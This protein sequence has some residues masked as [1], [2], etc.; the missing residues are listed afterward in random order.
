MGAPLGAALAPQ[1]AGASTVTQGDIYTVAG[2]G[3]Q[4][5][6]GD[7]GPA[8]SGELNLP[9]AV[10]VDASGN[11]LVGEEWG[12]RVRVVA[13]SASNPGYALAGCP[14]TCTWAQGDIYTVAGNGTGGYAGDAGPATSAE[15]NAPVSV[16][17]DASG[18]LIIGD[19]YSGHVRVV[20]MSASDPG[21]PLA[22]CPGTCT[23]A[24]GDIYTVAGNG[25]G[26][27]TGDGGP[28][29]S[30]ELSGPEGITQGGRQSDT[31]VS[32]LV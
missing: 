2:N 27:Y 23:W 13:M 24:Q 3:A 6:S 14:G 12:N 9:V 8:G 10:A 16:A 31:G 4:G 30:A 7:G 18:N 19:L 25:T 28:A 1:V 5:Y 21:Y 22:G 20:A 11:L 15:L 29:T 26:G 17:V 32:S